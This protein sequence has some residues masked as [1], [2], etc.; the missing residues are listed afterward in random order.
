MAKGSGT[1]KTTYSVSE[2]REP[3]YEHLSGTLYDEALDKEESVSII[4]DS[5][6]VGYNEAVKYYKALQDY[7]ENNISDTETIESFI[8]TAPKWYGDE[9]YRGM[10]VSD[11]FIK[12]LKVGDTYTPGKVSSWSTDRHFSTQHI[13]EGKNPVLFINREGQPKGTSIV[14]ASVYPTDSEVLVSKQASYKITNIYNQLG[15]TVVEV[16]PKHKK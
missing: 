11:N 5:N 12:N 16:T 4:M 3:M 8:K 15:M 10:N 1:T 13:E 14:H 6:H 7:T 2:N 9:T